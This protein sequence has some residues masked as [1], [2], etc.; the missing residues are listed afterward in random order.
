MWWFTRTV[1]EKPVLSY[2]AVSMTPRPSRV[3]IVIDGGE[4]WTFWARRALYRAD[5]VWGGSGFAVVPHREGKVSAVLLRACAAYDPDFVMTYSP[6]VA[7]MEH[8]YPGTFQVRGTDGQ[9]LTGEERE[10][11]LATDRTHVETP[12]EDGAARDQ[13]ASACSPYRTKLS[14]VGWTESD[15]MLD[16]DPGRSFP[17]AMAVPGAW[18]GSVLACPPNWGGLLGLAVANHAGAAAPPDPG[19]SEPTLNDTVR[20]QLTTWLLGTRRAPAPDE[21]VWHP[22]GTA[23]TGVDMCETPTAHQR[24]ERPHL[25]EIGNGIPM[26]QTGLLVVGDGPQDFALARLWK[27]TFGSGYWLPS[28]IGVDRERPPW[29]LA[30]GIDRIAGDLRRHSSELVISSTSH[31]DQHVVEIRDR[32]MQA[33]PIVV[34]EDHPQDPPIR[35]VSLSELPWRQPRTVQLAIAAQYDS[36]ITVPTVVNDT[37]TRE[38]LTPL[39]APVLTD[40]ELAAH[41]ELAWQVDVS[42]SRAQSVRGRGLDGQEL[43]TDDTPHLLTWGRSSRTGIVYQSHRYNFVPA[44]IRAENKLARPALRDLSLAEWVGAKARERDLVARPS[45]AGRRAALLMRM[46]GGREPYIDLFGG[47]LLPALRAMRPNSATTRNAFP[48]NDGVSLS[49]TQAVLTFAGVCARASDLASG[50]VRS[51]LD[52][53]L[54]A[55]VIRRGLV[56]RC[57][58]CEH[59]QFRTI[60]QIGHGWSCVRCDARNDLNQWAWKLPATEPVWFYD[61]H[62]VGHHVLQDNGDVPALLSAHL[63]ALRKD[64][65]STFSDVEEVEFLNGSEPQV[66]I[67]LVAYADDKLTVAECKSSGKLGRKELNKKCWAAALLRADQ[68]LLATTA[69]SWPDGSRSRIEAAISRFAWHPHSPQIVLITALGSPSAREEI[70]AYSRG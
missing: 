68:L 16:D 26:H 24:S 66:E 33:R 65:R 62:P 13:I 8:L 28:T 27:L 51:R 58:T 44:G 55:G 2:S 4:H 25:I 56:V 69:E 49:S 38:M 67:D 59:T 21:L 57:A 15:T 53:A 37:G 45:D 70:L 46:L 19:A 41:S 64:P 32:L 20:D 61:L 60:D 10:Q 52:A 48:D 43:F 29:S 31:S 23:A 40:P 7:E 30:Y 5:Q 36:S 34:V 22:D 6:T 54:K 12:A 39:P 11:R 63:R 42:W 17:Y 1:T 9:L 35:A 18:K 3:V 14:G 50:E 47:P